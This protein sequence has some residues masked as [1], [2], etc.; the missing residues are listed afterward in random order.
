MATLGQV[1]VT[2]AFTSGPPMGVS[3]VGLTQ[4]VFA[5]G[6]DVVF[7]GPDFHSGTLMGIAL[8]LAPTA[9]MLAGRRPVREGATTLPPAPPHTP[10]WLREPAHRR[11]MHVAAS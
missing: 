2:L 8:V 6:L 4:I 9:W 1:C 3:V 11:A 7:Y 5:L 10:I